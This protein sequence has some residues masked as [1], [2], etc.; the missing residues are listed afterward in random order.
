MRERQKALSDSEAIV[1]QEEELRGEVKVEEWNRTGTGPK[2]K[3][4]RT[5]KEEEEESDEAS[6]DGG[7]GGG[8][9]V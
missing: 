8:G 6:D 7:E 3:E 9:E 1:A 2:E 4:G 5:A